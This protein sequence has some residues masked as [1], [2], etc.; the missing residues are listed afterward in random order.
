MNC[1]RYVSSVSLDGSPIFL[2][3]WWCDPDAFEDVPRFD[4][5]SRLIFSVVRVTRLPRWVEGMTSA[6]LFNGTVKWVFGAILK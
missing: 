1:S 3:T 5:W 4:G 6:V 2:S